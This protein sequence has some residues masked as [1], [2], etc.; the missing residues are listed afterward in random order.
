VKA[1]F[2]GSEL[3]RMAIRD[4]ASQRLGAGHVALV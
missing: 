2:T 3:N 4:E 1:Q